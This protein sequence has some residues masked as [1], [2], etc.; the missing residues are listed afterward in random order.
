MWHMDK[1]A[2]RL[3]AI[4]KDILFILYAIEKKEAQDQ[5]PA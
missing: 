4:Q 3:S 5:S 2:M 1:R